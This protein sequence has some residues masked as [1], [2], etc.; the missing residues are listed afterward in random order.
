MIYNKYQKPLYLIVGFKIYQYAVVQ[1]SKSHIF[2]THNMQAG[3]EF[4]KAHTQMP[5]NSIWPVTLNRLVFGNKPVHSLQHIK[6]FV[7]V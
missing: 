2:K 3:Y 6:S 5:Q 4:L 7:N 1:A